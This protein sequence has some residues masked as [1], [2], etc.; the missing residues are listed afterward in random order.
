[1]QEPFELILGKSKV[2][3][4]QIL[5]EYDI[6]SKRATRLL[7]TVTPVWLSCDL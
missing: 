1:M 3:G 6:N 2:Y 7:R 5:E 4:G